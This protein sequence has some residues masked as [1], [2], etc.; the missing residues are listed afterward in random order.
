MGMNYLLD[1]HILLWWIFDDPKI[2]TNCRDII[3]SPAHHIFVS[4]ASEDV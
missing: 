1:T 2:N 4:S 3:G